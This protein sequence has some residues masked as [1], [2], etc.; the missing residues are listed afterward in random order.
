MADVLPNIDMDMMAG[1]MFPDAEQ[2]G[3]FTT[4]SIESYWVGVGLTWRFGEDGQRY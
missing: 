3:S 2:L 4:T 1:G